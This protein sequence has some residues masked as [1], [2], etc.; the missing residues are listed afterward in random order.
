MKRLLIIAT[1]LAVVF[2]LYAVQP[3]LSHDIAKYIY[4]PQ[5]Q[6]PRELIPKTD[7]AWLK[8]LATTFNWSEGWTPS[9]T[10]QY[11]YDQFN[12][13]SRIENRYY[14]DGT[15]TLLSA[16]DYYYNAAGSISEI[17]VWSTSGEEWLETIKLAYIYN[18]SHQLSEVR[19]YQR[20]A[21]EWHYTGLTTYQYIGNL[22]HQVVSYTIQNNVSHDY[23]YITYTYNALQQVI[24]L[25]ERN[26]EGD[27]EFVYDYRSLYTYNPDGSLQL[28][29][30]QS[31][32][33]G[34]SDWV[35]SGRSLYNYNTQAQLTNLTCEY[36]SQYDQSWVSL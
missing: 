28:I 18:T 24:E 35:N 23:L 29:V 30:N 36:Y 11:L 22:L 9:N 20:S 6:D 15:W 31:F 13:L 26:I 16:T 19:C 17:R 4:K 27:W 14:S 10:V 3:L 21:G 34:N 33:D 5:F 7:R 25:F 1:F 2:Y 12:R 8:D 32:D